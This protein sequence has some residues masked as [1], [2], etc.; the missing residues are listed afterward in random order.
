MTS[1]PP[2]SGTTPDGAFT[3]WTTLPSS[4]WPY[5]AKASV[6]A[7]VQTGS[8]TSAASAAVAGGGADLDPRRAGAHRGHREA[9]L[10]AVVRGHHEAAAGAGGERGVPRPHRDVHRHLGVGLV[11]HHDRQLEA[12]AEVEEARGGRAHHERQA[13]DDRRLAGAEAPRARDRDR[14]H[15]VAGEAVGQLHRHAGPALGVGGDARREEGER[16]EVGAGADGLGGLLL[17]RHRLAPHHLRGGQAGAG[18]AASPSAA[19]HRHRRASRRRPRAAA[20]SSGRASR[21]CER[22]RWSETSA[23]RLA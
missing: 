4:I 16:R 23:A 22:R 18:S 6:V 20:S 2:N 5:V 19:E 13:G 1:R 10:G 15:A 7:G 21:T 3:G 12:V 17:G 8:S 11:L 9:H 14:H